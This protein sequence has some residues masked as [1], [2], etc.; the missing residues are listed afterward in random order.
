MG[1]RHGS[2]TQIEIHGDQVRAEVQMYA[3]DA[4]ALPTFKLTYHG[5]V[6]I[7]QV[8]AGTFSFD[9]TAES[10]ILTPQADDVVAQYNLPGD[11]GCGL[12]GWERNVPKSVMGQRC[13]L[14]MFPTRGTTL[15]DMVWTDAD[16]LRFGQFPLAWSNVTVDSRPAQPL[17]QIYR[18]SDD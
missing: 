3:T 7:R 6:T 17:P 9:Q 13:G 4:C 8:S 16:T 5:H 14:F 12:K 2:I 15:Y 10:L 11:H 18:R 1:G